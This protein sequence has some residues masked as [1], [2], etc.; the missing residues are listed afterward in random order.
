M[1]GKVKD[2]RTEHYLIDVIQEF[3]LYPSEMGDIYKAQ[4]ARNLYWT[5]I[6]LSGTVYEV[7]DTDLAKV[8]EI[9]EMAHQVGDVWWT[10]YKITK[11]WTTDRYVK[12]AKE[13]RNI[14]DDATIEML[15]T[16]IEIDFDLLEERVANYRA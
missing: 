15:E 5:D 2:K 6:D 12:K 13:L 14:W 4:K 8:K 7:S 11:D 16:F 9:V 3:D 1:T 10:T